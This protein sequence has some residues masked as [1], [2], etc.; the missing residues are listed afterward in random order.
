MEST[1]P[2]SGSARIALAV[3]PQRHQRFEVITGYYSI[4]RQDLDLWDIR[5]NAAVN[6]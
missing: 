5:F 6:F 1:T 2:W 4:G 3:A